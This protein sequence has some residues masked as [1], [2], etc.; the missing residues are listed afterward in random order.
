MMAM[1]VQQMRC[2]TSPAR[3]THTFPAAQTTAMHVQQ[4][5]VILQQV[6][7]ILR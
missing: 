1:P 5:L 4:M 3:V 2:E 6:F 7:L